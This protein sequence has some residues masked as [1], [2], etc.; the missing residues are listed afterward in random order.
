MIEVS[1]RTERNRWTQES[2]SGKPV[3]NCE[4]NMHNPIPIKHTNVIP[5][6]IDHTPSNTTNGSSA[7][8][9]VFEDN[10]AVI[11]MICKGRSPTMRHVS[12][13]HRVAQDWLFDKINLDS[14]IQILFVENPCNVIAVGHITA[15]Y[16]R[17]DSD[18]LLT[19][20]RLGSK[21]DHKKIARIIHGAQRT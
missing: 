3:G 13:T 9:Y 18:I 17:H 15:C 20:R 1:F 12:R 10:E 21:S 16:S 5:T 4:Q 14:K 7:R 11:K 8:L 6:S 2:A 19:L